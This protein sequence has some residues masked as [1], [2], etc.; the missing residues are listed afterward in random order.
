MTISRNN[1]EHPMTGP[2][3]YHRAERLMDSITTQSQLHPGV[4]SIKSG[5]PEV[6]AAAQVHALLAL[7][8]TSLGPDI[9]PAKPASGLA[10]WLAERTPRNPSQGDE[11]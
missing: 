9:K 3:H 1:K 7:A 11:S 10:A 5:Y 4:P 2:E 6:I 8:A